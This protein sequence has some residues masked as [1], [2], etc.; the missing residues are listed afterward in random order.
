MSNGT[1]LAV[2]DESL[3]LQMIC[4]L[5]EDADFEV[6][7]AENGRQAVDILMANPARFDALV[8]DRMMP[9]MGGLEVLEF[10]RSHHD[11]ASIPV[12]LQTAASSPAEMREGIDAGAFYYITKPYDE[13]T[14]VAIVRSAVQNYQH[15]REFMNFVTT[16]RIMLSGIELLESGRFR[17]ASLQEGK[18]VV[19]M[20][21]QLTEESAMSTVCL[22]ELVVNAIE[23]GNLG[24]G[25]PAKKE[26][27]LENRWEEEVDRRMM[28]PENTGKRVT[29][30]FE[31][32]D[33][34]VTVAIQDQGPGFDWAAHLRQE[35][36]LENKIQG[37]GILVASRMSD[38]S[39]TYENG[40]SRA[41]VSFARL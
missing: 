16:D 20:L 38:H 10:V 4:D 35:A 17:F 37:R 5:L 19:W 40:G 7:K 13:S 23:H 28:L 18:S 26:L 31:V 3:T 24:I 14:L 15:H 9:E 41:I 1:I 30:E 12:I 6:E 34:T 21:S 11:T 2:D 39:L 27:I 36:N 8:V 25:G 32:V 22:Q 33:E 29:V